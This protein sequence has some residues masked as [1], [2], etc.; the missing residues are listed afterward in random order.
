MTFV[1]FAKWGATELS[2]HALEYG[3]PLQHMQLLIE[4]VTGKS[5]DYFLAHSHE[6]V[7]PKVLEEL[8]KVLKRRLQ[9][10][11]LQYIVGRAWFWKHAFQVGPG[12]LIPRKETEHIVEFLLS[13]NQDAEV[14]VAELG[15]GS[16]NL[17][18]SILVE[19]P[20]WVWHGFEKNPA[21]V[22]FLEMNLEK[23]GHLFGKNQFILH[24]GDFFTG[25]KKL[26]NLDYV[27]ANPPYIPS[28]EISNLSKE[29]Q[30]EP[31]LALDGGE[32]DVS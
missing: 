2:R 12:V 21:S 17:P 1:E 10:E 18:I 14:V 25:A 28:S 3:D 19:R 16:G 13:R 29:V 11:P 23:Y 30:C 7:D 32:S 15:S 26:K 31:R 22:P 9:G 4:E 8:S 20:Q 6:P 24:E 27:V 5:R